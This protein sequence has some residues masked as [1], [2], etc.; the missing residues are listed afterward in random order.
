MESWKAI[1]KVVKVVLK[2]KWIP[3]FVSRIQL[4]SFLSGIS[5][6][7]SVAEVVFSPFPICC[8]HCCRTNQS[9][10][11]GSSCVP[12]CAGCT[13][14]LTAPCHALLHATV[15]TVETNLK[16]SHGC[17]IHGLKLRSHWAISANWVHHNLGPIHTARL[18]LWFQQQR[19]FSF[20]V[21]TSPNSLIE[22]HATH[23]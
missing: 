10:W 1:W 4:W 21:G 7:A 18:H 22:D 17:N 11:G 14:P 16:W 23:F 3:N 12:A 2:F 9:S 13:N 15:S 5:H 20:G 6:V 8:Q 19:H